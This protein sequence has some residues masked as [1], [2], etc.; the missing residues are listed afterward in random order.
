VDGDALRK[1]LFRKVALER[2]SS[3][4]QLDQLVQVVTVR[5]WLALAPLLG[6]IAIA[7]AWGF[8]GSIPTKVAG[9]A[10]LIQT[11]GLAD[12]SAGFPGRIAEI[13]VRVGERVEAGQTVATLSQP[14]LLDRIRGAEDRLADL[15]RQERTLAEQIGRGVKLSRVHHEQQLATY[16]SQIRA[17]EERARVLVQRV[18]AQK[19]LLA[20]GL[21]TRQTLLGTENEL[22]ATRLEIETIKGHVQ[23]SDV[24]SAE[25][26]RRN[27]AEL[28]AV[29]AQLAEGKRSLDSLR[30]ALEQQAQVTSPYS[31]RVV[32]IKSGPGALIS[33]GASILTV[34]PSDGRAAELEALIFIPATLGKLVA[35]GMEAQIVPSTVKR[36]E[37]GFMIARVHY[38]SDYAATPE[39]MLAL[40]QNQQ[41]VRDLAGSTAPIEV[42]ARLEPAATAS[43]FRWSSDEGPPH[44][45]RSG[46]LGTVEIVVRTQRPA[47][48]V[49]PL[50]K[51]TVGLD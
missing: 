48:L 17:A 46:T 21:V 18:E 37:F 29:R 3:P 16:A 2:L 22:A 25:E 49:I 5:T 44:A 6:L 1:R 19:E 36:E 30:F 31:G 43:G 28:T 20:Q 13:R 10:L 26:H 4:E 42:R 32:E 23:F 47:S 38:V 45:V 39:S 15:R 11:A 9:R 8:F 14:D 40:L 27:D 34:E 35:H 51:K 41:M 7:V 33:P 12:V 50:L 24:R